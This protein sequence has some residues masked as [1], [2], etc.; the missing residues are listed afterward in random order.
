M[1]NRAT[2][3]ELFDRI[4]Q[5]GKFT[6]ADAVQEV[7]TVLSAVK[8]LHDHHVVHRGKSCAVVLR[9]YGLLVF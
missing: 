4:C 7:K 3:G 1:I 6:E 2:G 5:R 9:V 8:Y